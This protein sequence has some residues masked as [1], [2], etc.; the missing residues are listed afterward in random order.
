M[1]QEL[2]NAGTVM[3]IAELIPAILKDIEEGLRE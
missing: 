3:T 2:A 1:R